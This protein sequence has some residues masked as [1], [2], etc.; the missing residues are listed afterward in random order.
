MTAVTV[1]RG[2][3]RRGGLDC[4]DP[5]SAGSLVSRIPCMAAACLGMGDVQA[6]DRGKLR[7]QSIGSC[8]SGQRTMLVAA[9]LS[10]AAEF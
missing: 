2:K 9:S 6:R 1:D 7:F 8:I 3:E 4:R 5:D 10:Q